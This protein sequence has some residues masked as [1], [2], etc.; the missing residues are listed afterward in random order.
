MVVSNSWETECWKTKNRAWEWH[1][2][3]LETD[4]VNSIFI[5]SK[6]LENDILV[7][8]TELLNGM[9]ENKSRIGK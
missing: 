1:I 9:L 8:K 7:D 5:A 4:L 2:G 3:N 6:Q